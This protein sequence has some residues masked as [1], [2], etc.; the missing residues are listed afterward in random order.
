M[1]YVVDTVQVEPAD[2]ETYLQVVETC[3]I[4]IMEE[5]GARFVSCWTTA[6]DIG[7]LVEVLTAWTFENH[8]HWNEIRR[9][10]VLDPRWFDYS[11]RLSELW[12]GGTRRFYYATPFSRMQ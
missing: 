8:E 6:R 5:A 10:L 9:N 7:E 4:A 12:K 2:V 1:A 11:T 3:G